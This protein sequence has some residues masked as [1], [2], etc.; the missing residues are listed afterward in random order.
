MSQQRAALYARFSSDNQ[1]EESID[2]QAR[3]IEDFAKRNGMTL[4]KKYIDR[5]KSA[6]SDKRPDFQQ[7]M[8]DSALGLFDAVIV[9][10]LDR[11]SRDKYDSAMY[12]RKLRQYGVRLHSVTEN[13]DGSP[14]SIILESMLEGMAQY[15]SANLAREVMKGM[16]ENAYQCRH[17]GGLPPLGYDVDSATKKLVV[18]E[19]EADTVRLIYKLYLDGLGYDRI[20]ARLNELGRKTKKSRPFGKNSLHDILANEKY[21]GVYIFNCSTSKDVRGKRNNHAR[22]KDEDII[23]TEGGVPA[24]VS[25]EVFDQARAKMERNK[26]KPGAYRSE[27]VY[28]LSG[29]IVCGECLKVHGREFA[30]AGN[31]HVGG[32]NKKLYVSYRCGNR[33]RTNTPCGNTELRREYIDDFVI[34]E[35][36]LRIF[37]EPNVPLL[38]RKLNEHLSKTNA[39]GADEL[40]QATSELSRVQK[41]IE[42]I[43]KAVTSGNAF[44]SLLSK[45]GE[46]EEQQA[47]LETRIEQLKATKRDLVVTEDAMRGL[48][49]LFRESVRDKD[50]PEIKK[51]VDGYVQRVVVYQSHVEVTFRLQ[52]PGADAGREPFQIRTEATRTKLIKG[53]GAS[54]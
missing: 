32:R 9:H 14:E 51:F 38:T 11:F 5:A 34:H 17:T 19:E 26:R 22:K 8:S 47:V 40:K 31:R 53:S 6:T 36:Q 21:C 44:D 15:Y 45:M 30:M 35:L 39:A 37:N 46:L 23:R 20:M 4:V 33:D 50:I 16:K 2:A 7:M 25:R 42:N 54:V 24:I 49:G 3:A 18:N 10:K 28:L 13:L 29:R 41:Q 1:R 52:V 48:F 43:V 27:E 12:K